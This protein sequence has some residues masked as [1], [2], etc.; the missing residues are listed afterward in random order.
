MHARVLFALAMALT[1]WLSTGPVQAQTPPALT[2]KVLSAEEGAMEG[3]VISAKKGIVTVSVVSNDR[4]EFTFPSSKL[5]P[6]DYA[7]SIKASGYDLQGPQSVTIAGERPLNIDIKLVKAKNLAEQLTNQEWI[8]SAPGTPDQKRILSRCVNCH[9]LERVVNS[10]YNTQQFVDVIKRMAT[11]SNNS[12]FR[13]PQLRKA[14]RD[15]ERF[16]PNIEREAAYL[17][18]INRSATG[19]LSYPLKTVPRVKGAGTRVIVT[20]YDLPNQDTQPHDVIV[21]GTG[22]V[23]HSDFSGQVLGR[24]DPKTLSYKAYEVPLQRDGWPTGALDL[25]PDPNGHL[26][27]G[28]MFQAG[29]A[30]FDPKAEKFQMYQL[31]ADF[32]KSDSQQAMVA[33]QAWTV[34]NKLWMQ[35][36][37][38]PGVYRMDLTSGQTEMWKPYE[39]MKGPH[40]VYGIYADPQNNLWFLDFGGENVGM[41]DAKTGAVTLYPTPTRRSRPRRGRFDNHGRLWFAEFGQERV[42]VFDT[43]TKQFTEWQ[44][45]VRDFSPYDVVLDKNGDLWTGGMNAD[46]ILRLNTETGDFTEYPLPRYTNIRRVF[47][48]NATTPPTFWIGNN[49]GAALIKL[50]PLD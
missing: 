1:V 43:R 39:K 20:E 44:L 13:R 18:S 2:G 30:R 5:G 7:L 17:A 41:I 16:V 33:P 45:P 14:E 15:M 4:G 42:G 3:V 8:A 25:E 6:G 31:P 47:V 37:S 32:L 27:L 48:D 24:F 35:D 19:A 36:P 9:S 21:D 34:D 29:V 26:W 46:R 38:L 12:F 23:W 50:E 22:I 28:L 11:Y 40:S 10:T 49:H